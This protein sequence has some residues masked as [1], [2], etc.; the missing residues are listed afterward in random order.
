MGHKIIGWDL[1]SFALHDVLQSP[2]HQVIIKSI[3]RDGTKGKTIQASLRWGWERTSSVRGVGGKPQRGA[4][5]T[6]D[7]QEHLDYGLPLQFT[8]AGCC[9]TQ[10]FGPRDFRIGQHWEVGGSGTCFFFWEITTD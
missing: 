3:C 8:L 10:K 7:P 1:D 9:P 4:G 5:H 6:N 2:V